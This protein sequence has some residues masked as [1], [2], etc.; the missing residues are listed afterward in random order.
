MF[1]LRI[2]QTPKTPRFL[3]KSL[4]CRVHSRKMEESIISLNLSFS[5]NPSLSSYSHLSRDRIKR[6]K[7]IPL[8]ADQC[9]RP[10][11]SQALSHFSFL[12]TVVPS[13]GQP[14]NQQRRSDCEQEMRSRSLC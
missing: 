12:A 13:S 2:V 9:S 11:P 4:A 8:S 14:R 1:F 5:C 6:K 7:S 10:P 3:S